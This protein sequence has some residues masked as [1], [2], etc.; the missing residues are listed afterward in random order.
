MRLRL[1]CQPERVGFTRIKHRGVRTSG[2]RPEGEQA[3]ILE[4]LKLEM[5]ERLI[6][7]DRIL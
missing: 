1:V 4:A 7:P 5:P 2:R 6:N 3:R